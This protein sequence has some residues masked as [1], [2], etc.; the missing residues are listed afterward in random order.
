MKLS[1]AYVLNQS[2]PSIPLGNTNVAPAS[3]IS[4]VTPGVRFLPANSI[5]TFFVFV[6]ASVVSVFVIVKSLILLPGVNFTSG[7]GVGV[8]VGVGVGSGL[9]SGFSCAVTVT[10]QVAFLFLFAVV[11][12]IVASP[13]FTA[14]TLPFSS[15][16]AMVSSL[17]VHVTSLFVALL[18]VIVATSCW[19][20]PSFNSSVV[21]SNSTLF[22]ETVLFVLPPLLVL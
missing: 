21:L 11:T 17:E 10:A 20:S 12:V 9:G 7:A 2:A 3:V 8:G 15:T 22:T 14:V 16:V 19:L 13:A 4:S 18:G 6:A 5:T 1:G